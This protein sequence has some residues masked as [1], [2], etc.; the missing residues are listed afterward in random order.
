MRRTAVRLA[1]LGAAVCAA[2]GLIYYVASLDSTMTVTAEFTQTDAVFP[3]NKVTVLGVPTGRITEVNPVGSRVQVVMSLPRGTRIPA[4][5]EAWVMS[6]SVISDRTI[7]LDPGYIDG[8][9]LPDGAV[10]PLERTHAPLTWD[11]LTRS[12]N[13][14]TVALG[15][16][17]TDAGAGI[18]DL[19]HTTATALDGNGRPFHDAVTTI[20][21]AS[22]VMAGESGDITALVDSLSVLV[23]TISDN[24]GTVDSLVDSITVTADQFSAQREDITGALSSLTDVLGQVSALL[25]THG[26]G[27][28][29][30]VAGLGE[31]TGS[32]AAKQEQLKE[33]LETAPTGFENVANLVDDQGRAR[34]RLDVSTNLS[35]FPATAA[36]C[37]KLPIPLCQGPGLVNPIEFPPEGTDLAT[38]LGGGR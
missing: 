33:I 18:G 26:A 6:P 25:S 11:Q 13:D 1:A 20:S 36:L 27:L 38:I 9:T 8:P 4:D 37:D 5:A 24:Q 16:N 28:T 29:G 31:L 32:I 2:T 34:V 7:E 14:L 12:V 15:P 21:Q 19:L 23:Q 22:S 30:D 10:I 3:G 17:S 35:Q